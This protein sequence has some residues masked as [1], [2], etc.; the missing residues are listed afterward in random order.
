MEKVWN[1]QEFVQRCQTKRSSLTKKSLGLRCDRESN[2]Q[3]G[4]VPDVLW[5]DMEEFQQ[6]SHHCSSPPSWA[7][8][9]DVQ[10]GASSQINTFDSILRFKMYFIELNGRTLRL[11]EK[12]SS[13]QKKNKDWMF[14]DLISGLKKVSCLE[15]ARHFSSS[16]QYHLY[17]RWQHQA[18]GVTKA[19]GSASADFYLMKRWSRGLRTGLGWRFTFQQHSSVDGPWLQPHW[20]N[21]CRDRKIFL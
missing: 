14:L 3:L 5:A 19:A 17:R 16:V 20:T 18:V 11:W 9:Q 15:E 6:A 10:T 13:D 12:R 21:L 2:G 8:C 4:W 1:N 7:W